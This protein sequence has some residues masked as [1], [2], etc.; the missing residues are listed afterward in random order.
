MNEDRPIVF[1]ISHT[2]SRTYSILT[3]DPRGEK[4]SIG[5]TEVLFYKMETI[6]ETLNNDF[7]VL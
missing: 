4:C 6:V 7:A 5:R 3:K 2:G 1:T